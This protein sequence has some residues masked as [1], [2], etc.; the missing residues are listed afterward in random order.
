MYK[1]LNF[2]CLCRIRSGPPLMSLVMT[3]MVASLRHWQ[4]NLR[5]S[6]VVGETTVHQQEKCI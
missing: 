3:D 2:S 5:I 4:R 6:I 1:L